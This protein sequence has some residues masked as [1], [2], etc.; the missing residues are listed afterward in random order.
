MK[1]TMVVPGG[2]LSGAG[3]AL[4]AAAVS[5]LFTSLHTLRTEQ[6]KD[7]VGRVGDQLKEFY[8]P[9][10]ACITAS[11]ESCARASSPPPPLPSV[12]DIRPRGRPWRRRFD[13]MMR[14]VA[15]ETRGPDAAPYAP[16]EFREAVRGDARGPEAT[17]YRAWVREVLLPLSER[18]AAIVTSRADLLEGK[19]I[20]PALLQARE[21]RPL[22]A[23]PAR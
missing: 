5:Y 10:L 22:R 11:K 20:D 14:Q 7:L 3:A 19:R 21:P 23:R 13:A 18:A 6:H 2:A 1:E 4:M 15:F 9:L 16:A 12:A 8:G 17:A